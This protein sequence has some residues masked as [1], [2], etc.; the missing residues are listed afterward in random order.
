MEDYYAILGV[1]RSATREQ[2]Q[3][4][5]RKIA[6]RT[7]PDKSDSDDRAFRRATDA[8][9]VLRDPRLRDEYNRQRKVFVKNPKIRKGTDIR[10]NLE[11]PIED[12]IKGVTKKFETIRSGLCK[13][14]SGTGSIAQRMQSCVFCN[15]TGT[16]LS[17]IVFKDP[18][19]CEKCKGTGQVPEPPICETCKGSGTQWE[20]ITREIKVSPLTPWSIIIRGSGHQRVRGVAGDLIVE[21]CPKPHPIY[22]VQG[23]NLFRNLEISPAQSILGDTISIDVFGRQVQ[24]VI[25]PGSKTGETIVQKDEGVWYENQKGSLTIRLVMKIPRSISP[26]EKELYKEILNLE[27]E[28][29]THG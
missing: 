11:I 12:I 20:N 7:H 21:I 3:A 1:S 17:S 10:V 24:V 29:V 19:S 22:K 25:E 16:N 27:K 23:L 6:L 9:L 5:Y 8:Y 2:I 13:D 15:G 26:R 18:V 28:T 4:A 14:C